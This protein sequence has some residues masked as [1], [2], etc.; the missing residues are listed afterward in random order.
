VPDI[1]FVRFGTEVPELCPFLKLL[2]LSI[3]RERERKFVSQTSSTVKSSLFC[4][5]VF[6]ESQ[7]KLLDNS[8]IQ[9]PVL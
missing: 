8:Y 5:N 7:I 9:Y 1:C 6:N 2:N 3:Y 4:F